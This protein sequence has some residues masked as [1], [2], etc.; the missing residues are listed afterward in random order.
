MTLNITAC[1]IE[2]TAGAHLAL[3]RRGSLEWT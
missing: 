2:G 1:F 3:A